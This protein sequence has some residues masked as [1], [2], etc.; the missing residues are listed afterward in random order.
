MNRVLYTGRRMRRP[1]FV[2]LL[3]A[4]A[5]GCK[6]APAE[7][8]PTRQK[9]VLE[10]K[11]P[12]PRGKPKKPDEWFEKEIDLAIG[13]RDQGRISDALKRVNHAKQQNP[14]N[15]YFAELNTLKHRLLEDVLELQTITATV[16]F[17]REPVSFGDALRVRVHLRNGSKRPVR[18]PA[19]AEGASNSMFMLQVERRS[20]DI[21]ANITLHKLMVMRPLSDDV[22]LEPGAE[23]ERVLIVKPERIGNDLPLDGF[24]TFTVGGHLRPTVLELGGLRRW[25]A[26]KLRAAVARSFRPNYEHL[27]DDPVQRIGQAI[28]KNAPIHLITAA[29]L[30]PRHQRRAAVDKLVDGLQ[31]GRL[32]DW[33]MFASLQYLTGE[34]LGRDASA[35]RAWWPRVRETFFRVPAK[36]KDRNKNEPKFD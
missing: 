30:V 3:A 14:P 19:T 34:K 9:V 29:A 11:A 2:L 7:S 13:E 5:A 16:E 21:R 25:E 28:E 24:R 36:E 6:S 4:L 26:I 32:L 31:G 20:Y 15:P 33:T 10:N 35:W 23:T 8:G 17:D 22:A 1:V 27:A 12:E 18:I